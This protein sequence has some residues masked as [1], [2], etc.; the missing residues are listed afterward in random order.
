MHT[1]RVIGL[2][3]G[4]LLAISGTGNAEASRADSQS[5]IIDLQ[6]WDAAAD[7]PVKL[8]G[9]WEL[10]WE[11]LLAPDQID[12]VDR[13]GYIAVPGSW[14]GYEAEG[15]SLP[16]RGFAT[17]RVLLA[18]PPSE[19]RL[20][21]SI[22]GVSTAYRLWIDGEPA[23][24][25]GQVGPSAA[26]STAQS[27]PRT[28]AFEVQGPYTELVVQVSN[29]DHRFGGLWRELRVG[30]EADFLAAEKW[31]LALDLFIF[32]SLSIMG[33]YHIGVFLLRREERALL[34]F[35]LSSLLISL[36]VLFVGEQYMIQL[37]PAFPWHLAS[38]IEYESYYLL[39]PLGVMFLR[40]L[41]PAEMPR[42]LFKGTQAVGFAFAAYALVAPVYIVSLTNGV[43][44]LFTLIVIASVIRVLLLAVR[45]RREGAVIL[46]SGFLL[47]S[48]T[49][50]LD[51]LYYNEWI[52]LG[53]TGS[54]GIFAITVAQSL[55]LAIRFGRSFQ[56]VKE[57]S[58]QLLELNEGLEKKVEERTGELQRSEKARRQFL[59]DITH[60]LNTPIML[61]QGYVEAVAS[62]IAEEP[63]QQQLLLG[64]AQRRIGGLNRLIKDLSELSRLE[65]G[66]FRYDM[67]LVE[68]SRFTDDLKEKYELEI[69][70]AGYDTQSRVSA[71]YAGIAEHVLL[72]DMGRIDQV[73]TNIVYNAFKHIPQD[74]GRVD[75]AFEASG[76]GAAR[77]LLVQISDNGT[78][79]REEE[80]ASV[81]VRFYKG[82][83]SGDRT[84]SGLGLTIA[85]QIVEAHGG[86]IGVESRW[87]AG[88]TFW[89]ALP[90]V[91]RS[92]AA[93]VAKPQPD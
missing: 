14:N 58:V 86:T 26:D 9:N 5:G 42:W 30:H 93:S 16:G 44:Q 47:M 43:Y 46:L 81:F 41:F 20:A 6:E 57:L 17:Y 75:L 18:L 88:S 8:N 34:Y 29:F 84:A 72:V 13:T 62:G 31:N 33:A 35:G 1:M 70:N 60:E 21:L 73:L 15:L 48:L 36:R 53:D 85:K 37:F 61:I 87:G 78:G 64:S 50:V 27:L 77:K 83:P 69:R 11:R 38:R 2:L 76:S 82:S 66:Q 65:S 52:A 67:R 49:V 51:M 25:S 89:F 59:S 3:L 28:F 40:E 10:Y 19:Q 79:I 4:M 55:A 32:G 80:L 54:L 24:G 91:S 45:R 7:G 39:I 92:E 74:G 12:P 90:A 23:G 68:V 63:E 22:P 56:K 71:S